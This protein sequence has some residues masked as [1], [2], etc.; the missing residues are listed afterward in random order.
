[1]EVLFKK[2]NKKKD[3][4]ALIDDVILSE[5]FKFESK[6]SA[7]HRQSNDTSALVVT[8]QTCTHIPMPELKKKK[9]K[10]NGKLEFQSYLIPYIWYYQTPQWQQ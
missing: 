2:E 9:S 4:R 5:L 1:M 7:A 8:L 10:T 6:F 3:P